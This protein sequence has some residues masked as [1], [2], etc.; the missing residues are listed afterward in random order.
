MSDLIA[1]ING[2]VA[3]VGEGALVLEAGAL[4][5]HIQASATTL[6]R[7]SA[8]QA[9]QIHTVL[10]VKEND[11]SLIGFL[12]RE[13]VDMFNLLTGVSGVGAKVALAIQSTL[14][15]SRIALAILTEEADELVRAPGVGKKLA[16]RIVLELKDKLKS[17]KISQEISPQQTISTGNAESKQEATDA[18]LSLGYSR[19][20]A[21]RAVMEI[22]LTDMT[23][24]QIIRQALK[25]LN[26]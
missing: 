22:A 4:G 1:Y 26:K 19:S 21:L 2:K 8:G 7:L 15:S 11:I 14:D 6:S 16:N 9:V 3:Q 10:Q 13:D 12:S 24:E 23:A 20:E 18:L 17:A 25:H 5:Y